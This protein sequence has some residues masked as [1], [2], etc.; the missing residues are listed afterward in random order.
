GLAG[1]ENPWWEDFPTIDI[2][3]IICQDILHGSHKAFKDHLLTWLTN[4]IGAKEIDDRFRRQIKVHG[5][6][7]FSSGISKMSQ[8]SMKDARNVERE[9]LAVINGAASPRVLRATRAELDFIFTSQWSSMPETVVA[10]LDE[11]NSIYHRYKQVF[12]DERGR[13]GKGNEVIPHFNIPKLHARHHY[14][15]NI[16]DLGTMDNYSAE[17]T[18]SYH[19]DNVKKAYRA[20]NRKNVPIQMIGY[21]QRFEAAIQHDDYL[22]YL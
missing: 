11:L 19:V 5:Y 14:S 2:C 3:R 20:T 7:S 15:S 6:R 17:V 18:E 4:I 16:L 10:Q 9:L 21:M 13:L 12:I 8:W 1:I 22:Q